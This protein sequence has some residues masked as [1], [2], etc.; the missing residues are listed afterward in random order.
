L[1]EVFK[2]GYKQTEDEKFV[3]GKNYYSR[4]SAKSGDKY[5]YSYTLETVVTG[6]NIDHK[7]KVYYEFV[8]AA[9]LKKG[10]TNVYVNKAF[11]AVELYENVE[12]SDVANSDKEAWEV[13]DGSNRVMDWIAATSVKDNGVPVPGYAGIIEANTSTGTDA[14]WVILQKS[15]NASVDNKTLTYGWELAKGTWEFIYMPGMLKFHPSYIPSKMSYAKIRITAFKYV[16]KYLEDS[17]LGIKPY[18][19]NL[20]AMDIYAEASGVFDSEIKYFTYSKEDGYELAEVVA[21]QSIPTG[22]NSTKYYKKLDK[23]LFLPDDEI[24]CSIQIP[25]FV[26]Q[27][28]NDNHGVTFAEIEYNKQGSLIK[29]TNVAETYFDNTT[30]TAYCFITKKT[31]IELMN[32]TILSKQ[33]E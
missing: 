18:E 23:S 14:N 25:G 1:V 16:G 27:I 6:S 8:G 31:K 28:I 17:S 13:K 29:F 30:F 9:T 11:P 5:T 33:G 24:N 15:P 19:F 32:K 20:A 3:S 26:T 2:S 4:T 12:M 10:S 22:E 7:T 21:G